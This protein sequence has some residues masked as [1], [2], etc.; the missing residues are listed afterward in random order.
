MRGGSPAPRHH[1][2]AL[3]LLHQAGAG[4]AQGA[5]G[6]GERGGGGELQAVVLQGRTLV[7]AAGEGGALQERGLGQGGAAAAVVGPAGLLHGLRVGAC[8]HKNVNK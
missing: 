6:V 8:R 1:E 2:G 3:G 5:V 7:H 4:V